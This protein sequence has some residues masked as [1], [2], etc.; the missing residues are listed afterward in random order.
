LAA[1]G[2][3]FLIVAVVALVVGGHDAAL[4]NGDFGVTIAGGALLMAGVLLLVGA[5]QL[6]GLSRRS[7]WDGDNRPSCKPP[8]LIGFVVFLLGGVYLFF[9]AAAVGT[10]R[11][12][13]AL[14][15]AALIAVSLLGLWFFRDELRPSLARLGTIALGLIGATLAAWQFWYQHEYAPSRAGRAVALTA[16]LSRVS[17]SQRTAVV[18]ATVGFEAV[19][20]KSLV[21]VGSAYTLT[22]ARVVR[23]ARSDR[24]SAAEVA[25]LFKTFLVD[26]QRSR[27][28][29]DV[30]EQQPST[31][32]AAGKFVG[33][34]LRLEPS[35][36][37]TRSLVFYVPRRR[38][39]LLRFRAQVFAVAASVKLSRQRVPE[40]TLADD[41]FVYGFLRID[42][43]S[44]MHDLI[45]GRERWLLTRYELVAEPGNTNVAP[46][47]R[48]SGHLMDPSWNSARPTVAEAKLLFLETRQT[49][50]TEPFATTE[51]ALEEIAA[52][53]ADDFLPRVCRA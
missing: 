28:M 6:F 48:V 7:T 21:V 39:Q 25:N 50:P 49:N 14:V 35:V 27:F 38:Y 47:L 30:R 4:A 15:A 29:A 24:A 40:Y 16:E 3:L 36:P 32:L 53:N 42:D 46:D 23:C 31:V 52:P 22:G 41:N 13:V 8:V 34:G 2:G 43:D 20:G 44:W 26:P 18:T 17:D 45:S 10:Q 11:L 1:F 51:L 12:I 5:Y 9:A 33:D 37:Y 19:A